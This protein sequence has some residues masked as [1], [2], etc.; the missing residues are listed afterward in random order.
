MK[1]LIVIIGPNG[2]GKSTTAKKI[3]EQCENT[4][5][6]DSDWCRYMNP[7]DFTETTK[8]TIV[9]NIYCLLHNYLSCSDINT[10]VF[11]YGWHGERKE[12]YASAI[13]KL[14]NDSLD[15]KE[16]IIILKCT[17]DENIRRAIKDGRDE[18][19][20]QRGME[21]TFSFYDEYDYPCIDTTD[22]TAEQ[23]AFKI[24]RLVYSSLASS[25]YSHKVN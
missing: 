6:V 3:V 8:H 9:D 4:A 11:T 5:F 2:V 24:K 15:F 21:M 19:R 14:R 10:V 18:I 16:T 22:M 7:F 17:K 13:E 25:F 1:Q 23:V 20:V 12:I